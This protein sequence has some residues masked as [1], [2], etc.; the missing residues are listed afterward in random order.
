[1]VHAYIKLID[2]LVST[3]IV[4]KKELYDYSYKELEEVY[5]QFYD[6]ANTFLQDQ[7]QKQRFPPSYLFFVDD[8]SPNAYA[9]STEKYKKIGFHF[10]AIEALYYFF[11]RQKDILKT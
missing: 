2:L 3:K 9:V 7:V 1:M 4:D 10:G 8:E 5:D 6:F 11:E